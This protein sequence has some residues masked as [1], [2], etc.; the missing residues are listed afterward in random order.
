MQNEVEPDP[1]CGGMRALLRAAGGAA[2]VDPRAVGRLAGDLLALR[3]G[4]ARSHLDRQNASASAEPR[5]SRLASLADLSGVPFEI[6]LRRE[7]GGASVRLMAE[8]GSDRPEAAERLG[9][10]AGLFAR[11]TQSR[12]SAELREIG[13]R[14]IACCLP[15]VTDPELG[16]LGAGALWLGAGLGEPGV[17]LHA[18][19]AWGDATERWPRARRWLST[20]LERAD[21]ALGLVDHLETAAEP[22]RFCLEGV[23]GVDA[24]LTLAWRLMPVAT[25]AQRTAATAA[26]TALDPTAATGLA[27]FLADIIGPPRARAPRPRDLP[28]PHT[29]HAMTEAATA[30]NV[31]FTASFALATGRC[32]ALG[33]EVGARPLSRPSWAWRWLLI[34]HGAGADGSDR[35]WRDGACR[36]ARV[37]LERD[38]DGAARTSVFLDQAD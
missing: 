26:M 35:F 11:L 29:L 30:T 14:T 18:R 37:G 22:L 23:R 6:W 3:S 32:A 33:L 24:R 13:V 28:L 15:A 2:G 12:A 16:E 1:A 27:A 20:T 19:A 17:V 31:I 5:R 4:A 25:S 36:L 38:S 9:I 21:T 8:P 10:G 34:R 7:R